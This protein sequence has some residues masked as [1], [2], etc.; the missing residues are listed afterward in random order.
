ME[1]NLKKL[2]ESLSFLSEDIKPTEISASRRSMS[3]DDDEDFGS[4]FKGSSSNSKT[5]A[6][7]NFTRDLTEMAIKGELDPIVGRDEEI[8]R[9]SQILAR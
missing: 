1:E 8:E 7:D 9:V 3:E 5:P 6:L 2:S 4:D